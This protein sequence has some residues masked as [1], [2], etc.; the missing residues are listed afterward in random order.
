M[1][2]QEEKAGGAVTW[3]GKTMRKGFFKWRFGPTEM[4]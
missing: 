3:G 4:D 1:N 2:G